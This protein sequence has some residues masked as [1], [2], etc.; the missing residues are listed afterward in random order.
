MEWNQG[1]NHSMKK[2]SILSLTGVLMAF[3]CSPCADAAVVYVNVD[4]YSLSP[5][6]VHI[7]RGD[8][9]FWLDNDSFFGPFLITGAWGPIVTPDWIQFNVPPGNYSYTAESAYGGG[10]W[11]GT[12][13]VDVNLPPSVS[14]TSPTN[15]AMFTAPG[16][17][18]IEADATDPN[19][20]DLSDVEFWVNDT[21]VDDVYAYPYATTVTNLA[22]GTYTLKAI[23]WD[24]SN[25]RATNSISVQVVSPAPITLGSCNVA[26][27]KVVFSVNGLSTGTTNVL[28]SSSNLVNWYPILTNISD[29]TPLN[30]TNASV[31]GAQFFRVMQLQ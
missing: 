23:A 9:V 26:G 27:G 16:S 10:P 28:Q 6:P 31:N 11:G 12:V 14:I 22:P 3:I 30:V 17:F 1:R 19:V 25:A 4:Y 7:K 2:L 8:V 5:D 24:Y 29:G 18:A 20:N 21:L 13:V 15:G